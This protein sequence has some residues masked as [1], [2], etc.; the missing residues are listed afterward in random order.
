MLTP[1]CY[2]YRDF[3][4]NTGQI[5]GSGVSINYVDTQ[6]P[7][8]AGAGQATPQVQERAGLPEAAPAAGA[9]PQSPFEQPR[10]PV[11][12]PASAQPQAAPVADRAPVPAP[13]ATAPSGATVQQDRRNANQPSERLIGRVID[14][15]GGFATLRATATELSSTSSGF[16][17]IGKL[18]SIDT[19]VSRIAGLVY[20]I[21]S[22]SAGWNDGEA[23][24]M[25]VQ[26]ELMGEVR[27]DSSGQP[28]FSRGISTYP[29]LGAVAHRIRSRDL[30]AV[31]H[32]AGRKSVV[33]GQLSQDE[34]IPAVVCI[35]DMI[36]R[37]FAL[38]GST[39]SG[40]STAM[41]LILRQV[42][43]TRPDLRV[44]IL[45][46]HNEFSK[47]FSD[48]SVTLGCDTLELPFW[49][50]QQE[51]FVEVVFRGRDGVES[52][53]DILR[54]LIPEAK[55]RY[56]EKRQAAQSSLR[57]TQTTGTITADTPVP[58][59]MTDRLR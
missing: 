34:N 10:T 7:Q 42:I 51:E 17:S 9:R 55:R 13:P 29:P 38:V 11:T 8:G 52:E 32:P 39:G 37:H 28:R 20:R 53:I 41:S 21:G 19:D 44:L 56:D 16:W 45:D 18:I 2:G 12:W 5:L 1:I 46:P 15:D 40:K 58:Y 23:N 35:E 59:R 6:S 31:H 27:D 22:A 4:G 43:K 57:R 26:V 25:N 47:A 36:T 33:I 48:I 24:A 30:A 49:L 14:C 54:D 50:F 3:R